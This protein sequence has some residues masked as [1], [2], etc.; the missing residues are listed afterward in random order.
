MID[1]L[2]PAKRLQCS[3]L[4]PFYPNVYV[5]ADQ[6]AGIRDKNAPTHGFFTA[7]PDP[8]LHRRH[9]IGRNYDS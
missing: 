3:V 8:D 1:D 2:W 9:R 4:F 7:P 6:R 5:V